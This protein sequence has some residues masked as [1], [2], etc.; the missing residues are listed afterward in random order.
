MRLPRIKNTSDI[1]QGCN[2]LRVTQ[3][4]CLKHPNVFP[5]RLSYNY[6]NTD[7]NVIFSLLLKKSQNYFQRNVLRMV[8]GTM[9]VVVP[10]ARWDSLYD[11]RPEK[12]G[13][14]T[15]HKSK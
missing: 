5:F 14:V 13:S 3:A 15:L 8:C 1:K 7:K 12:V 10:T 9:E 4:P 6:L 2:L 11:T